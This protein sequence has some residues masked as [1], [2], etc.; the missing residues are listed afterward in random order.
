MLA[1]IQ[2]RLEE[3]TRIARAATACA[4]AGSVKEGVTLRRRVLYILTGLARGEI[5]M[6]TPH[7]LYYGL[8]LATIAHR[9]QHSGDIAVCELGG[10]RNSFH[11]S[12][13]GPNS[14]ILINHIKR[15]GC[16]LYPVR[17]DRFRGVLCGCR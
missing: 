7:A 4:Q 9:N 2:V 17:S 5:C 13:V 16:G 11:A 15:S 6:Q 1:A 8:C 12:P 10:L 3:A 14:A